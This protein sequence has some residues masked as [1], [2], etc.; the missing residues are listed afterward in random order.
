MIDKIISWM[1]DFVP[2]IALRCY[3]EAARKDFFKGNYATWEEAKQ[4]STGY[5]SNL[6]LEKVRSS[7][8]KIRKG[9]A[10]YERDSVL[11]DKIQYSWP[12]LAGLLW[13]ATQKENRLNLVDFGG[14]L[15]STYY[16][17]RSFLSHLKEMRWSIV[18]QKIFTECGKPEFENEHLKFYDDLDECFREQRPNAILFSSVLQYLEKPYAVLDKVQSLGF[19]FILI[20]RT[21]FL[22]KGGDRITVQKVPPEIYPASYPCWFLGQEKFLDAMNVHYSLLAEFEGF[23]KTDVKDSVFKGFIFKRKK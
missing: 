3:R 6:I 11:F 17:N 14:S 20:D 4:D 7:S 18:E 12:L 13:I 9:E 2:P 22:E 19:E 23:D 10:V 1:R 21:P 16:Q 15:G 8:L 5:D